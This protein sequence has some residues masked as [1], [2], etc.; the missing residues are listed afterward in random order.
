MFTF[1]PSSSSYVLKCNQEPVHVLITF[2]ALR[3]IGTRLKHSVSDC[4]N[5]STDRSARK[6]GGTQQPNR[7]IWLDNVFADT[8]IK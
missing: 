4:S 3:S 5:W 1:T 2:I 6:Q 7:P 8:A